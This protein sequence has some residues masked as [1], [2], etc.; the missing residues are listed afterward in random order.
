M[1]DFRTVI[2][3]EV[4][5]KVLEVLDRPGT[6]TITGSEQQVAAEVTQAIA[7]VVVNQ[8]NNEPLWKS[9]ILRGALLALAGLA[10]GYLGIQF[11]DGDLDTGLKAVTDLV[12][13]LG[14]LY[15]IYGRLTSKA[16]PKL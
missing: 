10:G 5:K 6:P 3:G 13:A 9:R 2:F 4:F 1:S 16:A 15:S 8:T 11:T 7:P 14:V 12:T